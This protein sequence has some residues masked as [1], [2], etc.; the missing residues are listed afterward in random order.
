MVLST[1]TSLHEHPCLYYPS[2]VWVQQCDVEQGRG[3][4][5][6]SPAPPHE[7]VGAGDKTRVGAGKQG[8]FDK[9]VLEK[10]L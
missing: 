10:S 8:A 5:I 4:L 2:S 1:K 9:V 7:R 6:P 3:R